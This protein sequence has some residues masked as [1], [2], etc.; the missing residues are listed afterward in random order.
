MFKEKGGSW[1]LFA[2]IGFAPVIDCFGS[3]LCFSLLFKHLERSWTGC[4]LVITP[5]S[6]EALVLLWDAELS[7]WHL[8]YSATSHHFRS[9]NMRQKSLKAPISDSLVVGS[10]YVH[11]RLK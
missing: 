1:G 5:E 2:P 10:S 6:F 3:V 4:V 7:Y 9:L 11:S 8:V